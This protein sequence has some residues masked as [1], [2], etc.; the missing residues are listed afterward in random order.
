MA[1]ATKDSTEENSQAKSALILATAGFSLMYAACISFFYA[2]QLPSP[3]ASQSIA[4]ESALNISI[5]ATCAVFACAAW[6]GVRPNALCLFAGHALLLAGTV[7]LIP[8]AQ[9]GGTAGLVACAAIAG[10]GMSLVVP[11]YFRVLAAYPAKMAAYACGVMFL[12]GMALNLAISF[13]A[14][15]AAISVQ[16]MA[17]AGSALCLMRAQNLVTLAFPQVAASVATFPASCA[18]ASHRLTA[19][20]KV[21]AFLV[22]VICTFA[23]S[24]IYR[25]VDVVT[26]GVESPDANAIAISQLGG[27]VAAAAFLAY[28]AIRKRS[29]MSMLFN[30]VFGLLATGI[31]F[32]PFL[33]KGYA[34]MLNVF[35]ATGWKLA[36]ISLLVLAMTIYRNSPKRLLASIACAYALPRAGLL[37]GGLIAGLFG[38][39]ATAIDFMR[40]A[41]IAF[42]LLYITLMVVWIMDYQERR[43]AEEA[44]RQATQTLETLA[45]HEDDLRTVR[46]GELARAHALTDR[47]TDILILLSQGRDVTFI[48]ETLFLSKNTVK[49]YQKTIYAKL[50][51]H[52]KREI[53]DLF[54]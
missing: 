5:V 8:A 49:S 52:S 31:L 3:T 20:E 6:R 39:H 35:A 44:A 24:I 11:L 32:L 23:L 47:E 29:S 17:V 27:I 50:D 15:L 18:P 37:A 43:Q 9:E 25:I 42:F 34:A 10:I 4:F 12:A 48:G 30:V 46:A 21:N 1:N 33:D 53:I 22:P 14:T 40:T 41:A 36:T 2:I 38:A 26:V 51:V 19:H 13:A 16:A 28:T 7:A 45:R 54:Q